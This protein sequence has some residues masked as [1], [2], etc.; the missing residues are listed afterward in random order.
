MLT[1]ISTITLSN[2]PLPLHHTA[3][4][5]TPGIICTPLPALITLQDDPLRLLR[6]VRF[7]CRFSFD[8]SP[9]LLVASID[10][11]V[12]TAL[13]TKVSNTLVYSMVI[14]HLRSRGNISRSMTHRAQIFTLIVGCFFSAPCC[15]VMLCTVL[16]CDVLLDRPYHPSRGITHHAYIWTLSPVSSHLSAVT[17]Q[18]SPVSSHLSA[19]TCQQSPIFNHLSAVTCQQS[20]VSSHL[21]AVTCQQSPVSSHLSA[22]TCQQPS[23][24]F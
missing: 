23:K 11:T 1:R 9:E 15:V 22:V 16:H 18:Q 10:P 4:V 20:P 2:T 17:C 12:R 3:L 13:G 24:P 21:S 6:A 5:N 8:I 14:T 19:V 7:A